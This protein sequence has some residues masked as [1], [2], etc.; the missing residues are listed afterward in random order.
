M[1][2][3]SILG[4]FLDF[5]GAFILLIH[6]LYDIGIKAGSAMIEDDK[7]LKGNQE[8]LDRFFK[9]EKILQ[10][11]K[12]ALL[13]MLKGN[14][15]FNMLVWFVLPVWFWVNKNIFRF[16]PWFDDAERDIHRFLW[17]FVGFFLLVLGF[18]LQII[19]QIR[20]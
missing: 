7:R 19:S 20:S 4:L 5:L 11:E 17:I 12:D 13:R 10:N 1:R 2:L 15:M 9:R 8:L 18:L 14:F 6:A 16:T 3:L